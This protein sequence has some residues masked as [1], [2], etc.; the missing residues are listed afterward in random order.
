[1]KKASENGKINR[2]NNETR[3]EGKWTKKNDK[4]MENQNIWIVD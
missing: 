2:Q 1:M 4:G 3:G